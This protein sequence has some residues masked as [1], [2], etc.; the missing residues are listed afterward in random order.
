MPNLLHSYG[1]QEL[2]ALKETRN[3][4]YDY[5]WRVARQ[6]EDS[7][8][9]REL[10]RAQ[11]AA[12][13]VNPGPEVGSAS[14]DRETEAEA[15]KV[16]KGPEGVD[17]MV[18]ALY[19]MMKLSGVQ[20]NLEDRVMRELWGRETKEQQ[21]KRAAEYYEKFTDAMRKVLEA[22][23]LGEK[24]TAMRKAAKKEKKERRK[25]E[26][27]EKGETSTQTDEEKSAEE[28]KMDVDEDPLEDLG[29]QDEAE[30]SGD[31]SSSST[32]TPPKKRARIE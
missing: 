11:S 1:E 4:A 19:E 22:A 27:Q 23:E 6:Q 20:L 7:E 15:E 26:K 9:A 17:A 32:E 2:W 5:F 12:E 10:R 29:L 14:S 25:A 18:G 3:E 13:E 30:A 21:G 28:D 16:G 24:R 31:E 8:R